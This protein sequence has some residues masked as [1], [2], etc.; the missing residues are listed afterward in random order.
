MRKNECYFSRSNVVGSNAMTL[1][2]NPT[3][4]FNHLPIT[5]TSLEE[6]DKEFGNIHLLRDWAVICFRDLGAIILRIENGE[7]KLWEEEDGV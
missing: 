4:G 6:F 7:S 3:R 1:H 2:V 5:C